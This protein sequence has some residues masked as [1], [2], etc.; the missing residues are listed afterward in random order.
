ML[1]NVMPVSDVQKRVP[2]SSRQ[3]F[4][5]RL[6]FLVSFSLAVPFVAGAFLRDYH[7]ARVAGPSP[8]FVIFGIVGILGFFTVGYALGSKSG[9]LIAA[10]IAASSWLFLIVWAF[11]LNDPLAKQFPIHIA[12]IV[13]TV[14]AIFGWYVRSRKSTDEEPAHWIQRL[15][16]VKKGLGLTRPGG[17]S[18]VNKIED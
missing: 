18:E 13:G 14:L 7:S 3:R 5:L 11:L 15:M 17:K 12:A 4:S 16:S 10:T 2:G 9:G 8:V 1:P 6:L